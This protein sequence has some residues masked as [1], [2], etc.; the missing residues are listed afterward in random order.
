VRIALTVLL[1]CLAVQVAAQEFALPCAGRWFVM[2]GGDT[3]NVNQHM[4]VPAQW[5]GVDLAKVGGPSGRELTRG[6]GTALAD[7][8]SWGEPVLAPC[9]GELVAVVDGLPDNALGTNDPAHPAGNHVVIKTAEGRY[10]FLGHLQQGTVG[11]VAG[12]QVRRGERLGLCGNSGHSDFPHIHLHVQDRP[13]LGAGRG[14]NPIFAH[15]DVELT[16]KAFTDVTW[17]LIR[18]LFVANH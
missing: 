18:G 11:V 15:I 5:Y 17:P 2:Q 16:G 9:A 4:S 7:F 8:F 10:V 3:P 6:A 14:H 1:L 12:G 13:E